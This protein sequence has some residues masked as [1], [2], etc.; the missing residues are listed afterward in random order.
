MAVSLKKPAKVDLSKTDPPKIREYTPIHLL[1]EEETILKCS[2]QPPI[3]P[4][5][6][7]DFEQTLE[8]NGIEVTDNGD[9]RSKREDEIKAHY[10]ALFLRSVFALVM[11]FIVLLV[12]FLVARSSPRVVSSSESVS[13]EVTTSSVPCENI[14][15][16]SSNVFA[17]AFKDI[18]KMF[19]FTCNFILENPLALLMIFSS[20]VFFLITLVRRVINIGRWR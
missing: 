20:G 2:R 16:D 13:I 8:K 6:I 18:G 9:V 4:N 14:S 7:D 10:R 3:Q 15:D 12:I 17:G 11:F 1:D 5:Q 19:S